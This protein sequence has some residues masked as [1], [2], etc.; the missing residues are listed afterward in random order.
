VAQRKPSDDAGAVLGVLAIF[1]LVR[2]WTLRAGG[3]DD[4]AL[5]FFIRGALV[6][7]G[8]VMVWRRMRVGIVLTMAGVVIDGLRVTVHAI[9]STTLPS[10]LGLWVRMV[11]FWLLTLCWRDV[12]RA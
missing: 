3:E 12:G 2:G 6:I 4:L 1:L 5:T 11:L 9:E 10:F 8:A 7:P